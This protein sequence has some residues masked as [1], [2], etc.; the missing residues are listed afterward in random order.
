MNHSYL[1]ETSITTPEEF[2]GALTELLENAVEH[3]VDVR[4]AWDVET[5]V[6]DNNWEVT[7]VELAADAGH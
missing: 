1:T 3:G 7:V 4:G 6:V 5:P 2:E